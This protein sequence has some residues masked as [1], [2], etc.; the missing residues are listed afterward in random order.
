MR[1]TPVRR[2]EPGAASGSIIAFVLLIALSGCGSG[3]DTTQTGNQVSQDAQVKGVATGSGAH[4]FVDT[5]SHE[6]ALLQGLQ[7]EPS[8][9]GDFD[10]MEKRRVIRALVVPNDTSYF[11]DGAVQRGVT[12]DLMVEFE[13]FIN[14][15]LGRRHAKVY[16][17]IL[18][19]TRDL[20]MPALLSG[21][22][23]IAAANLTITD[24]RRTQVDF[25]AP[26]MTG[27]RE[28]VVTG[29]A[30]AAIMSLDDLS[31]QEVW[32]RKTSS[33]YESLSRL[34]KQ[35]DTEGKEPVVIRDADEHLETEDLLEMVNAGIIGITISDSH[36]AEFWAQIFEDIKVHD[37]LA[38]RTGGEIAWMFRKNSP[39]L[40]K[41]INAFAAKFKQGTLVGNMLFTEYLKSTKWVKSAASEQDLKRYDETVD[42]FRKYSEQYDF[43]YLM[44]VAQGYQESRLNQNVRSSAG[45]IGIMQLLPSTAADPSI[46]IKNIHKAEPNVHAGIKYMR[47]I[48]DNYFADEDLEPLQQTLFAFASY[49]AGPSRIRSLRNKAKARGLDPDVWFDNVEVIAAEEIGRETLQYVANIYKYY[50]AYTLVAEQRERRERA[51]K[52]SAEEG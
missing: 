1:V 11:L 5:E 17:V 35:F 33:Y 16:V 7:Q 8:W 28:L 32:V 9:T 29:P 49:N 48:I 41:E 36:I 2:R 26:F 10:G 30:A 52:R 47:W 34:N 46:G 51:I 6:A 38:V 37:D 15:R 22:G 39:K 40:A 50:I 44:M 3:E 19:V 25:S 18:P 14:K 13:K 31:G 12:Y 20:L 4:K 24:R 42:F 27:V 21:L 45:A 23:D 43:N